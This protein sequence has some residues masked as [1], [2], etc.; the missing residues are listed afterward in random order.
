[1]FQLMVQKL[2]HKKWM[3]LSLLVGIVLLVA[4]ATSHVMYQDASLSWMLQEAFDAYV[5]VHN[6]DPGLLTINGRIAKDSTDDTDY[7]RAEALSQTI[8]EDLGLA[9]K[10]KIC[11]KSLEKTT[12]ISQ[13]SKANKD[14]ESKISIASMSELAD[15]V[16]LISGRIYGDEQSKDGCVEAVVTLKAAIER[17]YLVDEIVDFKYLKDPKGNPLKAKIVGIVTWADSTDDYWIFSPDEYQEQVFVSDR[18]YDWVCGDNV[19]KYGQS[20]KW[21]LTF[22]YSQIDYRDTTALTQ[23]TY[24]MLNAYSG[25]NATVERPAYLKILENFAKSRQKIVTTLTI[26]QVPMLALLCA[27]L[28]MISRQMYVAEQ[29]E[30]ALLRSRGASRQQVFCLYLL[31]AVVLGVAGLVL[32]L[33][34]GSLFCRAIGS[35]SAFMEFTQRRALPVRIT[36]ETALYAGIAVAAAIVMMVL[37]VLTGKNASIVEQKRKKARSNRP[38]WQKL[39]LDLIILAISLY[40]YYSFSRQKETLQAAV[41]A[42]ESLDPLLYLSSSLFILGASLLVLRLWPYL[43]KLVY[44]LRKNRWKPAA[45]AAFLELQRTGTRLYFIQ[46]FLMLTVAMG[47]FSTC[48]A[49]T[50]ETNA[51]TSEAYHV[52]A[53]IVIREKWKDNSSQR[54]FDETI[55]LVYTE[56]DYGKYDLMEGIASRTQVY[57]DRSAEL[58]G[59]HSKESLTLYGIHTKTFGETTTLPEGC[60]D[61]HYYTYLNEM[62]VNADYILC[63]STFRDVLGYKVGDKLTYKSGDNSA[64]VGVIADFVDYFPGFT[65]QRVALNPDGSSYIQYNYLIVANL[66]TLQQAWGTIPYEI[67]FKLADGASTE[68][69]YRFAEDYNLRLTKCVDLV[70]NLDEIRQDTVFQGTNGILTMSFII[71]LLLC[72][73][74]YLIYWILSVKSRE[75]LFGVLRAMGLGKGS[76]AWMLCIEQFFASILPVLFGAGIGMLASKL[77]VPLIQ[78]AYSASDQVLPMEL[79]LNR[80]DMA[81]LFVMIGILLLVCFALL[82]RQVLK[83]GIAQALKL[84]ED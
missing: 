20:T 51:D 59:N 6:E 25:G 77:F 58:S 16:K 37:P 55:P 9:Q 60:M 82:A 79:V 10:N 73:I 64:V 31:Q 23:K 30:I 83:A 15:H 81:E 5:A 33:P 14:P 21:Y 84:G 63:S 42:G 62:A 36:G 35:A 34:L 44:L 22:D 7:L 32:G 27:F 80:S 28:F 40:G 61:Q 53:D 75:L 52:G 74:G 54:R 41:V 65:P 72:G 67:W 13:I 71:V 24:S 1:M 2:L 69:F 29:A 46:T 78:I 12:V 3:M 76:V 47:C 70:E 45:Y 48:V 38:M 50:I 57:V 66:S 8:C 18:M 68:G 19:K 4:V 17:D 49:R 11:F 26:L 43:V 56:A 39:C